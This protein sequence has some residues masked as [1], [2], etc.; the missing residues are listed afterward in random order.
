MKAGRLSALI[1]L[2]SFTNTGAQDSVK[3]PY[4]K[5]NAKAVAAWVDEHSAELVA[6][7]K[8]F[9]SNPELSLQERKTAARLGRSLQDDGYTVTQGVGGTGVVAVMKNGD[10]PTL[11]I[12]GD[13]DAL[14][15]VEE[16]GLPYASKIKLKADDGTTIGAMH[17][18]GHDV[19]VTMLVGV[20]KL[21]SEM[22]DSWSG[23]LV[24]IGQP[25]EEVGKGARMMIADG[26]FERFPKPDICL[27]LHVKHDL[28]S[29]SVGTLAG[30]AAA[31]VDSVDITIFGKGGHGAKP[32]GTVDPIVTAAHVIT[33][34]QTLVSRRVDPIEPA[35]VTVGSIHGGTKHNIIPAEVKLQLTVRSYT[36]EVRNTLLDGIREIAT[37]T[38]KVF[39]CPKPPLVEVKD[40]YTPACY[41]HPGLTEAATGLFRELLGED[42]VETNPPTMGGE[43]FGTF[44]RTLKVP[45][46][47]YSV[48]SISQEKFDAAQKPGADSLPTL[49]SAFYA[50][51]AEPTVR[52]A[53][54]TMSNLALSLLKK[55]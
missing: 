4:D 16:T 33:S 48:G 13:M 19:H 55:Q 23:T 28:Q 36:D 39:G 32:H 7:Y 54:G 50:P 29:G 22:R 20:G 44:A 37:D 24:L 3:A 6:A 21:L 41:N 46:L 25:A 53:V 47:Q 27:A 10:G 17:A 51:E 14:P 49:H 11:L 18:C 34:L 40:E 9:H 1:V 5:A 2:T 35:V 52:T 45:G 26:L 15:V 30:W 31:N 43:D 42:K 38:C 12:R 8:H